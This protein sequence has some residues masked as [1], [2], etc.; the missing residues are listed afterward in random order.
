MIEVDFRRDM[1]PRKPIS[2]LRFGIANRLGYFPAIFFPLMRFRKWL[3]PAK[4]A[5]LLDRFTDVVIEGFFRCGNSFAVRAFICAQDAPVRVANRTHAP[6]TVIVAARRRLPILILIRNPVDTVTS[7]MLKKPFGTVPQY[8]NYYTNYYRSIESYRQD[9]LLADFAE[10]T[11]DY[12]SI[13]QRLNKRFNTAF[14]P[15]KHTEEN[16][17]E[18]FSIIAMNDKR[19]EKGDVLRYS[20]PNKSKEERKRL[21]RQQVSS[22]EFDRERA[23]AEAVYRRFVHTE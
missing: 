14:V 17:R 6:A 20:T 4:G 3:W 10:I 7:L 15:F 16:V 18:V 19:A 8:F 22:A 21:I 23:D 2:N 9:F 12:G 5:A 13:V 11:E 1:P